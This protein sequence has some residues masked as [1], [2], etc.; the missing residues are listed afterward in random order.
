M[1]SLSVRSDSKNCLLVSGFQADIGG[2]GADAVG[3]AGGVVV[4]RG[5]AGRGQAVAGGPGRA[6]PGAGRSGVDDGAAGA[7]APGGGGYW[8]GGADR[9]ATDD[10]DADL[11]SVDGAQ[12]ALPVGVSHIG[13][14]GVGLDPPA[15]LL[16]D[17]AGRAG[18]GRVD[19]AQVDPPDRARHGQRADPIADRDGGQGEAVSPAGSQNR[20]DRRGG[21]CALSD[22]RGPRIARGQ[23]ARPGGAQARR[24]G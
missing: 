18:A 9:R 8:S 6:R 17:L 23:G 14:G 1:G 22:R 16:P 15:P 13:G 5:P 19:G 10:R 21:G 11:H 24:A 4:G 7:L 3:G 12:G 2:V 20:L